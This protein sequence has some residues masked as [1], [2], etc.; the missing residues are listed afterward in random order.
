[1]TG[2]RL[3]AWDDASGS[4][5]SVLRCVCS[6]HNRD[7]DDDDVNVDRAALNQTILTQRDCNGWS[8]KGVPGGQ[9]PGPLD[10]STNTTG[11]SPPERLG[12]CDTECA[13]NHWKS[14]YGNQDGPIC[15]VP[16]CG[17]K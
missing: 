4:D 12:N 15:D 13:H 1:M 17:G 14:G 6:W 7:D 9:I 10:P 3:Y 5:S 8:Y 11:C 2:S 16:G